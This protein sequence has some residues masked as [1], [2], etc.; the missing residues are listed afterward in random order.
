[1]KMVPAIFTFL[2]AIF[3]CTN[4]FRVIF[5][6]GVGKNGST[7]AV[8]LLKRPLDVGFFVVFFS[9]RISAPYH[10]RLRYE[11]G[12]YND[13]RGGLNKFNGFLHW[14]PSNPLQEPHTVMRQQA[15]CSGRQDLQ[16]IHTNFCETNRKLDTCT[17]KHS[18][19]ES[20][21]LLHLT[22]TYENTLALTAWGEG[23][24]RIHRTCVSII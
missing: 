14:N 5:T 17:F 20:L 3:S 4:Y 12:M 24:F 6:G 8:S 9:G 22:V 23:L 7:I 1:M 16:L 21:G 15:M 19:S 18:M 10:S 11:I 2:G 13:D